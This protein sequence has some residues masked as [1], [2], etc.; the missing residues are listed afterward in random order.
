[1]K[2][3]TK[4]SNQKKELEKQ[5]NAVASKN[6]NLGLPAQYYDEKVVSFFND[7]IS[8][9]GG[10]DDFKF[11]NEPFS[12]VN[13]A[14]CMYKHLFGYK[15]SNGVKELTEN[16]HSFWLLN[17]IVS[18]VQYL[19]LPTEFQVWYLLIKD[20]KNYIVCDDGNYN[21][22]VAYLL[23]YTDFDDYGYTAV[24]FYLIDDCL[25]LPEEY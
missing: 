13:G 14:Y 1:M 3:L 5:K 25:I 24:K 22:L 20:D 9:E 2:N 4:K 17:F 12:G 11:A 21:I 7:L 19:K 6:N 10:I 16:N 23:P 8:I 15:F 18:T